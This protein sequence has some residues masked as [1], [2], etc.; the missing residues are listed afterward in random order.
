MAD[1]LTDD[2]TRQALLTAGVPRR[3][4]DKDISLIKLGNYGSNIVGWI[5]DIRVDMSGF[6]YVQ[7]GQKKYSLF[8]YGEGSVDA[9]YLTARGLLL[10][11]VSCGIVVVPDLY[12][13]NIRYDM[14]RSMENTLVMVLMGFNDEG[15]DIM[16]DPEQHYAVQWWIHRMMDAGKVIV[17]Q[18]YHKSDWPITGKWGKSFSSKVSKECVIMECK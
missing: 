5:D 10:S 12:D 14:G 6:V 18:G 16:G 9:A 11:G 13:Y 2:E 1:T 4:H 3:Y 7:D 8:M 17:F 15:I